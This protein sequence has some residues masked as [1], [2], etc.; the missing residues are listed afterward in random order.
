MRSNSLL[1]ATNNSSSISLVFACVALNISE[2]S[3]ICSEE[4][5][6]E[7][8]IKEFMGLV[9]SKNSKY[10]SHCFADKICFS[11]LNSIIATL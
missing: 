11:L 6:I 5:F 4:L 10:L 1:E 7:V 9:S 3:S 2:A 8:R